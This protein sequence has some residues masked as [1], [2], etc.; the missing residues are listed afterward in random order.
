MIP[1]RRPQSCVTCQGLLGLLLAL[2]SGA[3]SAVASATPEEVPVI[4]RPPRP[5]A[6]DGRLEDA[7]LTAAPLLLNRPGQAFW[8]GP[9]ALSGKGSTC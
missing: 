3:W 8:G 7:W 2:S 4:P 6:I 9:Q 1:R 5:L